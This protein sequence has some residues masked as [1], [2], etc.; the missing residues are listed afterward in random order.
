M[1]SCALVY[2]RAHGAFTVRDVERLRSMTRPGFET[3]Q[4]QNPGARDRV[5]LRAEHFSLFL[6]ATVPPDPPVVLSIDPGQRGGPTNSFSVVQAWALH[7]GRYWL[8]ATWRQQA[9]YTEF[10]HVVRLFKRKYRPSVILV[11]ATGQ[12]PT[13]ISD[14]RT[15]QG[16]EIVP[17]NPHD[18]KVSRLR[19]HVN[20]IRG[21]LVALPEGARWVAEFI[22]E[23]I[24]FPYGHFD[25]QVDALTQFLDWIA[26]HPQL[27][28]RSARA[29]AVAIN[30]SGVR[31]L[32]P[33]GAAPTLQCRGAVFVR[34]PRRW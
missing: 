9:R 22:D 7:E 29:I 17:I 2:Y 10:R 14:I 27:A 3:L 6:P 11:E 5:H 32:P 31:I 26:A 8:L 24:Q 1:V 4:Q 18:D 25:D 23:L 33:R 21:G 19:K 12:G 20:A 30:S 13:L 34:G 28:M 15:E 16:M